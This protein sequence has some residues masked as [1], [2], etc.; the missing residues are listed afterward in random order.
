MKTNFKPG[1]AFDEETR[2]DDE[3]PISRYELE[4][5]ARDTWI[6]KRERQMKPPNFAGD[7]R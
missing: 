6:A 3:F 1:Q 4:L 2:A 7:D 5:I